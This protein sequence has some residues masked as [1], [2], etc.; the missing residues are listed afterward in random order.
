MSSF[1]HWDDARIFLAVARC[2]T[3]SGAAESLK[4]GIATL[5]RRLD[6]LEGALGVPLFTRH[7]TGYR[8]TDDGEALLERAERLEQAGLAFGDT[9]GAESGVTGRVRLATAENLANPLI[10]PSLGALFAQHPALRVEVVSGLNTVNLH[11]R[12]ADLAVRMVR[13][14]AGNLTIKR[15]GTLGF[16]LY[17]SADYL[18]ARRVSAPFVDDDFIGWAETHHH[19][20]AAKWV[21]RILRG[22]PCR[23]ET[24]TLSAQLAA[25]SAGAGLAVLP[26]F[27]AR[28]AGLRC[29][30]SGLGVDQPIWLV[31]QADLA[32]SR[33]VRV[34]ADH[35]IELFTVQAT[36]LRGET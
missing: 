9:S 21:Q 36:A 13:P 28:Q 4:I 17:G 30:M 35:L 18:S 34:V 32:H 33:R 15:L 3:L 16:G 24:N 14:E 29:L 25:A 1:V 5:S 2:G 23:L 11:R 27:L 22:R 31:M 26:H 7:Q 20:P 10:V 19:L 12:D 8:L 6:R